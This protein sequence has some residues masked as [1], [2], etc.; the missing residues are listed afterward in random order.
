MKGWIVV[1]ASMCVEDDDLLGW[2]SR[3]VAHARSL[4]P[5]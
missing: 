2:V 1:D 4:P 5:K 3:G